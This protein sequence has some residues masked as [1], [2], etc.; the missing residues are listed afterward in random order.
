MNRRIFSTDTVQ[1]TPS[2]YFVA[3]PNYNFHICILN[4]R[5][6]ILSDADPAIMAAQQTRVILVERRGVDMLFLTGL[7][8]MVHCV[9]AKS[10]SELCQVSSRGQ[11]TPVDSAGQ[12]RCRLRASLTAASGHMS[13]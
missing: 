12:R 2:S 11:L 1:S 7:L 5:T 3:S 6:T 10:Q 8:H 9:R 4:C 13:R